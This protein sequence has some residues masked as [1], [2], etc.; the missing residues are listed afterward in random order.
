VAVS[1][2]TMLMFGGGVGIHFDLPG[3]CVLGGLQKI[4][5]VISGRFYVRSQSSPLG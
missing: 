1:T 3:P 4:D 5:A 2:S